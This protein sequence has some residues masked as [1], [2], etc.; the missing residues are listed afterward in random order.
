MKIFKY[1]YN[2]M[3]V[4]ILSTLSYSVSAQEVLTTAPRGAETDTKSIKFKVMGADTQKKYF[5]LTQ[6]GIFLAS[7]KMTLASGADVNVDVKPLANYTY[8]LT[9]K[10]RQKQQTCVFTFQMQWS[11]KAITP[12]KNTCNYKAKPQD[13]TVLLE[14][15]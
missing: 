1:F 2:I 15:K 6:E 12:K 9:F 13:D 7:D 5:D 8:V 14:S 3:F 4:I 11:S 10:D